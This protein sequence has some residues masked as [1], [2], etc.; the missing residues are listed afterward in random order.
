MRFPKTIL[1]LGAISIRAVDGSQLLVHGGRFKTFVEKQE[2][3]GEI[4]Q[5]QGVK[6]YI[7]SRKA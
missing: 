6:T 5:S 7:V 4:R 1:F 3:I 2:T